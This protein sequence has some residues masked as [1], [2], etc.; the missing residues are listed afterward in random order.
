MLGALLGQ[1]LV[2]FECRWALRVSD[3]FQVNDLQFYFLEF[4]Q[5]QAPSVGKP[6]ERWTT[7][8]A[9]KVA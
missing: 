6:D 2:V 9:R 4:G 5:S 3:Y 8:F 7:M 1:I